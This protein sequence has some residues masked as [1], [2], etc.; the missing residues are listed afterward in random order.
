MPSPSRWTQLLSTAC[1]TVAISGCHKG[2][3]VPSGDIAASLTAPSADERTFD[4]ASL[5]GKPTLV[6]F[7]SPTCGHCAT[8][9][10]M[11]QAAAAAENANIV[12]VY[13]VGAKKNAASVAKSLKFTAPVL[14]DDGT[15][16]TRYDIKAVPYMLVLGPDGHAVDAFRGETDEATL[17]SALADAR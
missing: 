11:A 5:L 2:P 16:R 6:V 7:A 14:V 10:P 8:E 9:L 3:G 12:A 1:L 15:L 17:R 13:V 4:P